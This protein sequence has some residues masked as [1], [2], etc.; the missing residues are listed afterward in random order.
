MGDDK[1]QSLSDSTSQDIKDIA[2]NTEKGIKMAKQTAKTAATVAKAAGRAAAG[3]YAGAVAE[4]A[5]DPETIKTLVIIVLV[6]SLI[7]GFVVTS[8]LYA[9]PTT[10]FEQMSNFFDDVKEKY[11]EIKLSNVNDTNTVL[12][13]VQCVT[14]VI[15]DGA[16]SVLDIVWGGIKDFFKGL[17]NTENQTEQISDDGYELTI[18]VQEASEKLA[19]IQ[20]AVAANDK[21]MIRA[22]Q[23][24]E[25]IEGKQDDLETALKDNFEDGYDWDGLSQTCQIYHMGTD[26]Q[27]AKQLLNQLENIVNEMQNITSME[28]MEDK[29]DEFDEIV[30]EFFPAEANYDSVDILSLLLAQ[31]GGSLTDMKLSDFMRFLGYYDSSCEYNT[32]FSLTGSDSDGESEEEDASL[33]AVRDW[34]GTYKP[35]YLMEEMQN[36][37]NKR[38]E[39]EL[40]D[41]EAN[42]AEIDEINDKLEE[43]EDEGI[44]LMDWLVELRYP[45]LS[46]DPNKMIASTSEDG[47]ENF[48]TYLGNTAGETIV[49]H[50]WS[51]TVM[52]ADSLP[53]TPSPDPSASPDPLATPSEPVQT[54][55]PTTVYHRDA[56]INY[57]IIPRD[58]N[59]LV[60]Y[61]GLMNKTTA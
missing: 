56:T 46:L 53:E 60:D 32:K 44:A 22:K 8:F 52:V 38:T 39:L 59:S 49:I 37:R 11:E 26:G 31:Q 21:Y 25:A 55:T 57:V 35:Q 47:T 41:E 24:Q 30:D 3:D 27:D 43:Y 40:D 10:I 28:E 61:I 23:I 13:I 54:Y 14:S 7:L 58:L 48:Y 29:R 15:G 45:K 19:V 33:I 20:K 50:E 17:F 4:V 6:T 16:S 51:E 36:L 9:L 1:D 12:N 2:R 42:Q 5:K 34:K 18:I